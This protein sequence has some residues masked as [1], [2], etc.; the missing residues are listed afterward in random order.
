MTSPATTPTRS[1]KY[2]WS[3]VTLV[4]GIVLA[5]V[6]FISHHTVVLATDTDR[7]A[8]AVE[9]LLDD[10]WIQAGLVGSLVDP[11]DEFLLTDSLLQNIADAAAVDVAIPDVLDD[12][13][14]GL[15]QPIIEKTLE[16]VRLGIAQIIASDPFARSWRQIVADTHG[17]L[18]VLLAADTPVPGEG[19]GLNLRPFLVD[20]Q[21]G[22]VDQGFDF[23]ADV[24]LP[25]AS[26]PL[27]DADEV[28]SLR[29]YVQVAMVLDPW[30]AGLAGVLIVAGIILAPM[31]SRAWVI[32][33]G[34][35]AI[36][37]VGVVVTLWLVRTVWVPATFPTTTPIVQP[38]VD[39]LLAYPIS[40]ALTIA[41]IAATVGGVGWVVESRI[42]RQRA[43]S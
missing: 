4:V 32:A 30:A 26:I 31:R 35:V 12:A 33:G 40:Q 8:G 15:L 1:Q 20:I 24:P 38:V 10:P 7:V 42:L 2:V 11:L 21:Q 34:G 37:L 3:L 43:M 23:F 9:P 5:P 17:E 29:G 6:A 22:L 16:E 27:L 41:V 19:L 14:S 13:V 28:S 39:A 25:N 36:G 18:S